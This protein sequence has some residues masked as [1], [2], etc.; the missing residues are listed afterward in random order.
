LEKK[1]GQK[2]VSGEVQGDERRLEMARFLGADY[3]LDVSKEDPVKKVQ[4]ITNGEMADMVMDVTGR[5]K[6]AINALDLVKKEGTGVLPG[7]YGAAKEV[8]LILDK[9]VLNEIRLHGV[10]SHDLTAVAP[11]IEIVEL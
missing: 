8:P 11:A 9:V 3:C 2:I 4:E 6:E 1:A 7:L 5:P 10:Y